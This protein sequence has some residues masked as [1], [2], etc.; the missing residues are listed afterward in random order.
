MVDIEHDLGTL[1]T[2]RL[3]ALVVEIAQIRRAPSELTVFNIGG[4][5]YFENATSDVLAFFLDDKQAHGL[6]RLVLDAL[7][8]AAGIESSRFMSISAPRREHRTSDAK[9]IDIVVEGDRSVLAIENKVRHIANN[10]FVAYESDLAKS[11]PGKDLILILLSFRE[12]T[13]PNW[14][15]ARY[16]SLTRQ[17]RDRIGAL[18]I[19]KPYGKWTLLL[20]EFILTLEEEMANEDQ[21]I[22]ELRFAAS[23]LQ[24]LGEAADVYSRYLNHLIDRAS[25][26]VAEA[27][28]V[29]QLRSAN[30]DWGAQ[31]RALRIY[32]PNLWGASSNVVL[33]VMKNG[34]Y[35]VSAYAYG[36]P[37]GEQQNIRAML[38]GDGCF[39]FWTESNGTI[40]AAGDRTDAGIK[41][42]ERALTLLK[43]CANRMSAIYRFF[44]MRT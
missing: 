44:Q 4:R 20:R 40:F 21:E 37:T 8:S 30:H 34:G 13:I 29:D 22:A 36:L 35:G 24:A 23:N 38:T 26:A 10:D 3:E 16:Q 5:G 9:R 11:Y 27:T 19:D 18:L 32:C 25:K 39:E 17:L 28:H 6:Q 42:L 7:L 33:R 12:E 15:A 41:D 14:V 2:K 31:G 43:Q 1:R